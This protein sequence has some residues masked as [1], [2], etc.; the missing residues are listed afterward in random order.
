MQN[1]SES[2]SVDRASAFQAEG[3]GFDLLTEYRKLASPIW[4]SEIE[5]SFMS[6]LNFHSA[7]IQTLLENIGETEDESKPAALMH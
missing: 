5:N 1:F 3:R 6:R 7:D 4:T 2:S